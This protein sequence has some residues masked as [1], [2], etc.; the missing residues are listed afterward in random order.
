M[1]KILYPIF[2][3]CKEHCEDPFWSNVFEKLSFGITPHFSICIDDKK[4]EIFSNNKNKKFFFSFANIKDSLFLY[5][6]IKNLF[7][8]VSNILSK[9]DR[10]AI[11]QDVHSDNRIFESWKDIKKKTIKDYLIYRYIKRMKKIHKYDSDQTKKFAK[12]LYSALYFEKISSKNIVLDIDKKGT[13]ISEI[14]NINFR[15]NGNIVIESKYN[16]DEIGRLKYKSKNYTCTTI[17]S[18]TEEFYKYMKE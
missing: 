9:K 13:Y 1:S 18:I 11:L 12:K 4:K 10:L 6:E 16:L 14:D 7:T 2:L 5:N 15:E 8:N 17:D 3:S